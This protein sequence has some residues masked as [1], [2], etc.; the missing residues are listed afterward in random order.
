MADAFLKVLNMSISAG[1]LILAVVLIRLIIKKAPKWV[2]PLLWG[3][4]ALRLVWPFSIE[5][6]FSL[7]PSAETVSAQAVRYSSEQVIRSGVDIIDKAVNPLIIRNFA[8]NEVSSVNPL[9]ALGFIL[10]VIWLIGIAVLIIY[11]LV[12]WVGLRRR[13]STAVRLEDGVYQSENVDSPFVMGVL[14]PKI[15]LPFNM[16]SRSM[17]FVLAHERAHIARRDTMFKPLGYAILCMHWFNPLVWLAWVLFCRDIEYAC[18]ERVIRSM[19]R[20]QRA[21]YSQALLSCVAPHRRITASPLA[22]GEARVSER[23]KRVLKY[24]RPTVIAA[25]SAVLV[26]VAVTVCFLTNPVSGDEGVAPAPV[27]G[28]FTADNVINNVAGDIP[29]EVLLAARWRVAEEAN[30]ML[31]QGN[32][33]VAAE[34]SSLTHE[35]TH[36]GNGLGDPEYTLAFYAVEYRL[37]I[38]SGSNE[39]SWYTPDNKPYLLFYSAGGEWVHISDTTD[40]EIDRIYA[41]YGGPDRYTSAAHWLYTEYCNANT[42]EAQR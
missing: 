20:E 22:F 37:Q 42:T 34:L 7:I 27:N 15:Y 25:T 5:S 36:A 23:V 10:A 13:V 3:I 9:Y 4:V 39:D 35:P 24:K 30:R 17:E 38:D 33:I 8:P 19:S 18:D 2:N 6:A 1:W 21:D 29:E 32:G 28:A 26:L 12:S 40:Y 31:G 14:N 11:A 41:G 16:D